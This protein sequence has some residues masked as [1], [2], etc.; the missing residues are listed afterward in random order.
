M[1]ELKRIKL[2]FKCTD[3]KTIWR[4]KNQAFYGVKNHI[5]SYKKNYLY[6]YSTAWFSKEHL[7]F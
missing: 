4:E 7:S 6:A 1:V 2:L 3:F 5:Y